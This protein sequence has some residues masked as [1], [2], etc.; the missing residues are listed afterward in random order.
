MKQP[1]K[2]LFKRHEVRADKLDV[3]LDRARPSY[4]VLDDLLNVF[5]L[6]GLVGLVTGL[7]VE[8]SSVTARKGA[9]ASEYL[10]AVEPTEEDHLVGL[11][12]IKAFAVHFLRLEDEGRVTKGVLSSASKTGD[13]IL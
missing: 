1:L 11:G 3:L 8:Y 12:N 7:E 4:C 2:L 6:E 13:V 10:A 9:T 5:V